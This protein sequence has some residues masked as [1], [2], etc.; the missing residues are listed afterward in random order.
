LTNAETYASRVA[1]QKHIPALDGVR[2]FAVFMV[3][4]FHFGGGTHSTNAFMRAFGYLNK[5]GWCGVT[6]FFVLSGFLITGILWDS[7]SNYHWW[8]KFLARRTLRIFPLYFLALLLVV[9]ASIHGGGLRGTLSGIWIPLLFLENIPHLQQISQALPSPLPIFH[10]WSIAVEEQFYLLWP[11]VL[12]WART[13]ERARLLCVAVFFVSLLFRVSVALAT[14][15]SDLW[16]DF[17][18]TQAGALAAGGWLALSRRS[19]DWSRIVRVAPGLAVLGLVGFLTCGILSGTLENLGRYM[20]PV[21]LPFVTM[22]WA[23]IVALA[24]EPGTVARVFSTGWLRW[25]GNISYGVYVFH[26]LL[27]EPIQYI[28]HLL[29]GTRSQMVQLAVQFV[30]AAALSLTC[31][32]LSFHL[33]EKQF[34]RLKRFFLPTSASQAAKLAG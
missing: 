26:V 34:L 4:M 10:L 17:L 15:G 13:G 8:R 6:L 25:L 24:V 18:V 28:T 20:M 31:A 7:N 16:T 19:P 30:V 29:A 14:P 2:G 21:G 33:Y 23:S 3:F 9:L 22:L 32:W 11:F 27:I 1:R 5:G 12:Q